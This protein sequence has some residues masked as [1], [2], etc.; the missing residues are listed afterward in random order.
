[1]AHTTSLAVHGVLLAADGEVLA[2]PADPAMLTVGE[3]AQRIWRRA[4]RSGGPEIEK[5]GIRRGETMSEVLTGSGEEHAAES[6]QGIAPILGEL[7]TAGAAWVAERL[8]ER[9]SRSEAREIWLE[10]MERPG[11]FASTAPRS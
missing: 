1:M 5:L 3:L 4:G 6:R 8:P 11:F 10:A 7:P 9:G 2:G